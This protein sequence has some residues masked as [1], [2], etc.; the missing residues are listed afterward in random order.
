METYE[1]FGISGQHER[2]SMHHDFVWDYRTRKVSGRKTALS[3]KWPAEMEKARQ[4]PIYRLYVYR[5]SLPLRL[6]ADVPSLKRFI[7]ER[8]R[9]FAANSPREKSLPFAV[10]PK[11]SLTRRALCHQRQTTPAM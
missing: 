4:F 5:E 9:F 10:V 7:Q 1:S 2:P 3:E 6:R 11:S 8:H